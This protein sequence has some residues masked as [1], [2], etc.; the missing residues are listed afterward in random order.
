[1][2]LDYCQDLAVCRLDEIEVAI[3][4]YRLNSKNQF[5]PKSAQIREIV[6]ANQKHRA[7]LARI[8]PRVH[9]TGRP[10]LWWMKPKQHWNPDWRECEVPAGELIRDEPGG[11]LR[12][13]GA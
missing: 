13:A 3:R 9:V 1:M 5:F 6:F 11:P 4:E 2:W 12:G 7:E 8:G 10:M